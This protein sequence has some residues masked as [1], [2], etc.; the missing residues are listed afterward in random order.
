MSDQDENNQVTPAEPVAPAE[1][2][3]ELSLAEELAQ[4]NDKTPDEEPEASVEEGA[5]PEEEQPKEPEAEAPKEPEEPTEP[6]EPVETEA[7]R[8]QRFYE[9][10]QQ[11]KRE[12]KELVEKSI[13]QAYQPQPA[14]ELTKQFMEQGYSQFE[15]EMKA[16]NERRNQA[17]QIREARSQIT[18]LNS[19]MNVES[20]QVMHD[21]PVFD[22]TSPDYDKD[23]AD[24]ASAMYARAAGVQTDPKTGLVVSANLT[25]YNFYKELE[26]VRGSGLTKAQVQ[27]QRAAEQ[28]MASVAPPTSSVPQIE[29]T[30]EDAQ[31]ERL[32]AAFDKTA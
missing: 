32:R 31:A 9:M 4:A 22:P 21:Y 23:F 13:N 26:E 18:E 28:Q 12:Q 3:K 1:E 15:A 25:P 27:G 11:Q 17:E 30:S 24:K 7:E 2:G 5:R 19:R 8:K 14:D 16:D 10:R 6:E 29:K 20:V